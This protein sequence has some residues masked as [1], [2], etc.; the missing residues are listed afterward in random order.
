VKNVSAT[1]LEPAS[2][3]GRAAMDELHQ[4]TVSLLS[5]QSLPREQ[6]DAQAAFNLLRALG[7]DARIKLGE[8]E[9]RIEAHY[10]AAL[11]GGPALSLQLIHAP[12]FHGYV[13]SVFVELEEAKTAEEVEI[14]LAGDHVDLIAAESEPPSNLSSVGQDE[15]MV[16][17]DARCS[18]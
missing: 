5:F 15:I 18:S 8:T 11:D 13:A 6:Y 17:V 10:A 3:Y 9:E 1:V 4:Q 7:D 12:V 14:S 16:W 2:Q